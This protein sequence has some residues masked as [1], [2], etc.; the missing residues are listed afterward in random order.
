MSDSSSSSE[1]YWLKD[2]SNYFFD[3]PYEVKNKLK[4]LGSVWDFERRSW[5]INK[6]HINYQK[7]VSYCNDWDKL[8]GKKHYIMFDFRENDFMKSKGCRWD[9]TKQFWYIRES[10][11]DWEKI[12]SEYGCNITPLILDGEDRT[13]GGNKLFIDLIP[14]SCWFSNVR[15][16]VKSSEW[17]RIKSLVYGRANFICECCGVNTRKKGIE[18]N[19]HERWEFKDGVQK[20]K[21]LVALCKPCHN[22]THIGLSGIKGIYEETIQHY[23]K[24]IDED[25]E[26]CESLNKEA[27]SLW[28]Q[29]N[30]EEW[31]LDISLMTD[32]GVVLASKDVSK[33]ILI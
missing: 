11:S 16:C 3:A 18:I 8:L 9:K 24:V 14:K 32:N 25:L 20:L 28:K 10:V 29:R 17:N 6:K 22:V 4:K 1:E 30:K 26:Y 21:R 27:F 19:A 12:A 2:E 13:F 15:T 33:T 5:C 31:K 7:I 23:C